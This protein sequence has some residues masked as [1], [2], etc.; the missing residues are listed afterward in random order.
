MAF[1][2]VDELLVAWLPT[3]GV[4]ALTYTTDDQLPKNLAHAMPLIQVVTYGGSDRARCLDDV[5]LDIDVY[6]PT[7]AVSKTLAEQIRGLI[8]HQLPGYTTTG[9][10]IARTRTTQRPAIRPYDSSAIRR[11][12][13]AYMITVHG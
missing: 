4:N 8:I 10:T 3:V 12:Q 13:A 1:V 6:T 2:D 9:A 11:V 7:L 5:N